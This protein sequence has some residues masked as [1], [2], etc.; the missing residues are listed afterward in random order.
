MILAQAHTKQPPLL[1]EVDTLLNMLGSSCIDDVG[2]VAVASAS[3]VGEIG[4]TCI[5][6]PVVPH[7]R[8]RVRSM[9]V[10]RFPALLD[11]R[12]F[13]FVVVWSVT[14]TNTTGRDR[15]DELTTQ[16]LVQSHPFLGRGP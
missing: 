6:A 10:V 13:S 16:G 3:R 2:W 5:V 8:H 11:G 4:E 15:L 1:T 12:A 9:K 14:M 7:A